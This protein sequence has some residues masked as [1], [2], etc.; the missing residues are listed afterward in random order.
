VDVRRRVSINRTPDVRL[1]RRVFSNRRQGL[2]LDSLFRIVTIQ[3]RVMRACDYIIAY[4]PQW[5]KGGRKGCLR[6]VVPSHSGQMYN[7]WATMVLHAFSKNHCYLSRVHLP[8]S[9]SPTGTSNCS[10]IARQAYPLGASP[11]GRF[12]CRE[13]SDEMKDLTELSL[14]K[15]SKADIRI[16]HFWISLFYFWPTKMAHLATLAISR[17]H[18]NGT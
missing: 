4:A 17:M 2:R 13:M 11:S 12:A 1:D 3:V 14:G 9:Q 6:R 16:L 10:P 8:H 5:R 7:S 15:L 18:A